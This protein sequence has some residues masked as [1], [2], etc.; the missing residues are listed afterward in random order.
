MRYEL[1]KR[2]IY[3]LKVVF[4]REQP[5]KPTGFDSAENG[6]IPPGSLP[7]VPAAAGLLLASE[8]VKDI[9]F[10]RI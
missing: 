10:Q 2:G 9:V 3:H 8:V 6:K 4:S 7:F 5:L 1:K